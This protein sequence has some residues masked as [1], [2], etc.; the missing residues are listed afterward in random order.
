MQAYN[1]TLRFEIPQKILQL[2]APSAPQ[3]TP[4]S[5]C[6]KKLKMSQQK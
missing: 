4:L 5:F 2:I 6:R 3:S 1:K